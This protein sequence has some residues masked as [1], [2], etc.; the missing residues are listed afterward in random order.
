MP[1]GVLMRLIQPWVRLRLRLL[2]WYS[3]P[4]AFVRICWWFQGDAGLGWM[5]AGSKEGWL[6]KEWWFPKEGWL[7]R[8]RRLPR[9]SARELERTEAV[10]SWEE[11]A[12]ACCRRRNLW[13]K[14]GKKK[15]KEK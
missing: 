6:P 15:N 12:A 9:G 3:F 4:R 2:G 7:L 5:P 13:K 8:E 1:P 11:Q 14:G 10:R